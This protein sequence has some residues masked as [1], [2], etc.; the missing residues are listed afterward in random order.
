M[1]EF[2]ILT[3]FEGNPKVVQAIDYDTGST[4]KGPPMIFFELLQVGVLSG[5]V[6]ARK[7]VESFLPNF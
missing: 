6:L 5:V 4:Q 1:Q 2:D 7:Q 3:M